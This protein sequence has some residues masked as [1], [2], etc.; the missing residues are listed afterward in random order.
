MNLS[1]GDIKIEIEERLKESEF[2]W[3]VIGVPPNIEMFFMMIRRT[4]MTVP[5]GGYLPLPTISPFDLGNIVA[6]AVIRND[7]SKQRFRATGPEAFSFPEAAE[8]ITAITGIKIKHRKIPLIPL[9]LAGIFTKPFNPYLWHLVKY[10]K[11]FNNFP[12][13]IV[14]QVPKDHQ[15]LRETFN[16]KP[17]TLEMHAKLWKERMSE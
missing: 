8:K 16:Y 9:K 13:N 4:T 3:T 1:I 15:L 6:E 11:L 7:L 12:Q 5:G 17:T 2:N 14:D 10:V